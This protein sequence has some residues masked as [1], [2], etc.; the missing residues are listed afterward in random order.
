MPL[1]VIA[2]EVTSAADAITEFTSVF[3]KAWAFLT[4]NWY[5]LALICVPLGLCFCL[6]F[7]VLFGVGPNGCRMF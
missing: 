3:T 6:Q 2:M 1:S 4:S 5:F 7:L